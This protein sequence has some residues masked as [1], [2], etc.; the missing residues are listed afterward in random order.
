[1]LQNHGGSIRKR[2]NLVHSGIISCRE[3]RQSFH[4]HLIHQFRSFAKSSTSESGRKYIWLGRS[5]IEHRNEFVA[6]SVAHF[7][8]G[9]RE[10]D[11]RRRRVPSFRE[12]VLFRHLDSDEGNSVGKKRGRRKVRER[13]SR[14]RVLQI[15]VSHVS[16][17]SV[18]GQ[19]GEVHLLPPCSGAG[20]RS[21]WVVLGMYADNSGIPL[22]AH[23]APMRPVSNNPSFENQFS[24]ERNSTRNYVVRMNNTVRCALA[25]H[26][27]TGNAVDQ[28]FEHG[29]SG[30]LAPQ[31]AEGN[32]IWMI[33]G[34]AEGF[35][36]DRNGSRNIGNSVGDFLLIR[37]NAFFDLLI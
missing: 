6:A 37:Y 18:H 13:I 32:V 2:M 20:K 4:S 27:C 28:C 31:I 8:F 21:F 1:M 25:L 7:V 16:D 36:H 34:T 26:D 3:V 29:V 5:E 11:V 17:A 10:E 14:E 33:L 15:L 24:Q 35:P 12:G 9:G 22:F 23:V 19:E 30:N